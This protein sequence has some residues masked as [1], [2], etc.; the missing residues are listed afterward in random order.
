MTMTPEQADITVAF[1]GWAIPMLGALIFAAVL[2][3]K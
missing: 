1:L 3:S 2:V